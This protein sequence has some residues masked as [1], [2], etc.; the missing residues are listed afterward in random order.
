MNEVVLDEAHP[1]LHF[2][3]VET[4]LTQYN[5]FVPDTLVHRHPVIDFSDFLEASRKHPL[6]PAS[7]SNIP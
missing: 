3:D 4:Q 2:C 7:A 6:S 5:W 1:F